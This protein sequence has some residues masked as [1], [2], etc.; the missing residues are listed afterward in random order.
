LEVMS[1]KVVI[2]I[3]VVVVVVGVLGYTGRHKIKSMLGMAPATTTSQPTSTISPTS[4][5]S[6]LDAMTSTDASSSSSKSTI[7]SGSEFMFSPST[8]TA[9]VGEQVTVTFKNIGSYPHNFMIKDLNVASKTIQ[10]GGSDTVTFTPTKAG[11]YTY[12]CAVD[13]HDSKGMKGTLTVQ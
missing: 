12:Y 1:N 6:P 8:L 5:A 3:V 10:P 4:N 2:G 11:T 7:V 9:K 13:S